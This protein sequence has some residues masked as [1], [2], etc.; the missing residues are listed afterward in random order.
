MSIHLDSW[1]RRVAL[2]GTL[3]GLWLAWNAAGFKSPQGKSAPVALPALRPSAQIDGPEPGQGHDQDQGR[4][5]IGHG[6]LL[7]AADAKAG[8]QHDQ[9]AACGEVRQHIRRGQRHDQ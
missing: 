5:H 6:K 1:M 8:G 4:D 7:D 2:G 3:A 9:A